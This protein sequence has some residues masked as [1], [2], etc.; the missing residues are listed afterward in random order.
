MLLAGIMTV[1]VLFAIV[2]LGIAWSHH[3]DQLRIERI[4]KFEVEQMRL[5]EPTKIVPESI[6]ALVPRGGDFGIAERGIITDNMISPE[7]LKG[8]DVVN[9]QK[10][11][12]TKR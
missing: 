9:N 1:L 8:C 7:K 12:C 2:M 6:V 3:L 5:A 4:T 11:V 10:I